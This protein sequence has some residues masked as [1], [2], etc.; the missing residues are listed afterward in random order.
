MKAFEDENIF[1]NAVVYRDSEG[2]N[3]LRETEGDFYNFFEDNRGA[4][5]FCRQ[6][7]RF[8]DDTIKSAHERFLKV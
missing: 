6:M 1:E 3:W 2:K 8:D 7:L 5:I 4:Y